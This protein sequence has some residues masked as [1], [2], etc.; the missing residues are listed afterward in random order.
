MRHGRTPQLD[1]DGKR[2]SPEF[3][4]HR[5]G[6][7]KGREFAVVFIEFTDAY[8]NQWQRV[9]DVAD[10]P[11]SLTPGMILLDSPD[12]RLRKV[13]ERIQKATQG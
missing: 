10:H 7:E 2:Y 5:N 8:G 1:G 11:D 12:K 13:A 9:F 4:E 6:A 3:F